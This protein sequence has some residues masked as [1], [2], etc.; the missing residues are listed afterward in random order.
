MELRARTIVGGGLAG[1]H[2]GARQGHSLEFAGHRP[3]SPG[4]EWRRIDWKV[5]AKTDR[6]VVREEQEETNL[7]AVVLLDRSRS[8]SFAGEARVA[9]FRYAAMLSASLAYLLVHRGESVGLG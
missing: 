4:D 2:C 5:Y 6:W 1:R 3:Y 8:M 7:R 9:K